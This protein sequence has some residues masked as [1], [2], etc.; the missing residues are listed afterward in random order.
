MTATDFVGVKTGDVNGSVIANSLIGGTPRSGAT[1]NLVVENQAV[2]AGE[3]V[4]VDVTAS[5]FNTIEG[6]QFTMEVE[7]LDYR[8][9]ESG[10]IALDESNFGLTMLNRG[11]ITTSWNSSEAITA[12]AN[13]VLFTL[14]FT[15]SENIELSEALN[16]SSRYTRAEAYGAGETK[17]VSIA[18]NTLTN[19]VAANFELYQNEPNPFAATTVIGFNLPASASATITVYDVT[20]KVLRVVEGDYAKGYNEVTMKRSEI[21]ATGVLYYQLDTDDYSATKKM[22]IIE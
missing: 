4:R 18:F 7:G 21:S 15:A 2:K 11:M 14:V 12:S 22:V 19:Q 13:D 8:G 1:L 6:Y 10:A 17:D 16:V 5:N 3:E 20:G 9:V